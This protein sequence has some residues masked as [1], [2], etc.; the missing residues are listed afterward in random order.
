MASKRDSSFFSAVCEAAKMDERPI[1]KLVMEKISTRKVPVMFF[2][3]AKGIPVVFEL[4]GPHGEL[5]KALRQ[6]D[7][8]TLTAVHSVGETAYVGV[9]AVAYLQALGLVNSDLAQ[10]IRQEA[11]PA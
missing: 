4:E 10:K 6:N 7:D 2:H 8:G 1:T 11:N 3:D 5:K 9:S